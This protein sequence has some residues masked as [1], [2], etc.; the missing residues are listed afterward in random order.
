MGGTVEIS[1]QAGYAVTS[2]FSAT[3][4]GWFDEHAGTA[5]TSGL[6]LLR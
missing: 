5:W 3:S 6:E 4:F 1:P 2:S